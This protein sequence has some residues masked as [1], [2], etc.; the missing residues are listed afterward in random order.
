[1]CEVI[2]GIVT[3][4]QAVGIEVKNDCDQLRISW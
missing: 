1:M 3:V 4:F 2:L